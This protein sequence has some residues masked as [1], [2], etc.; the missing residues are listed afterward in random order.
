MTKKEIIDAVSMYY[1]M[2]K[3]GLMSRSTLRGAATD[4]IYDELYQGNSQTIK[5][6]SGSQQL[7]CMIF[8]KFAIK[9]EGSSDIWCFVGLG[10]AQNE[11]GKCDVFLI[12]LETMNVKEIP[13]YEFWEFCNSNS[14]IM[15]D[16]LYPNSNN[17]LQSFY[18][19]RNLYLSK[20][21]SMV[22]GLD[23]DSVKL[24]TFFNHYDKVVKEFKK[25]GKSTVRKS[26]NKMR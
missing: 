21:A 3:V 16:A 2:L 9:T 19:Y 13:I 6:L 10:N 25:N 11:D 8:S 14:V 4:K 23:I 1:D 26:N 5:K 15:L 20:I 7:A 24:D 17:L 18:E 22:L 12:D